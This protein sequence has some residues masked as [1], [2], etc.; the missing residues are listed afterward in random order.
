MNMYVHVHRL[1]HERQHERE[2]EHEHEHE[3]VR[4]LLRVRV[5]V[6]VHEH[7]HDHG[8]K[9]AR[10]RWTFQ[11]SVSL[12]SEREKLTTPVSEYGVAIHHL[13]GSVQ[14]GPD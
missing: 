13:C 14:D 11:R 3:H 6:R 8:H 2:H 5:C 10:R 4:V 12:V 9:L 1:E 7:E